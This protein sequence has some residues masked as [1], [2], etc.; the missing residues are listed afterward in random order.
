MIRLVPTDATSFPIV[1][2]AVA[3]RK[4]GQ[5]RQHFDLTT[6]SID[7]QNETVAQLIELGA[8]T[9]TSV[10]S[11]RKAT[12][13]SPIP[14]GNEL[15]IIEP[16]NN[17]LAD[18]ERLGAVNCDGTQA[19]GYFWSAGA[20]MAARVGPGRGD[21]DPRPGPHRSD[22][23][24]EWSAAHAE[25]RQEPAPFDIA[26]SGRRRSGALV[27]RLVALGASRVDT[28]E[29]DVDGVVMADPDGNEFS[30]CRLICASTRRLSR[31]EPSR[32]LDESW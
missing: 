22:D 23:H 10:R 8:A 15:C 31:R 26:P 32:A 16:T 13:C 21:G 19:V 7:D 14:E 9:S 20:R 30:C 3:D 2:R 25:A 24:V 1:F 28:D 6:T 17:F 27:E 18:C 4:V 5:N 12:S 29:G 11:P